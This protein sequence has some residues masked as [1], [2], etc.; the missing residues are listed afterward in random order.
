MQLYLLESQI[1]DA[2]PE[3]SHHCPVHIMIILVLFLKD[4]VEIPCEQ[5]WTRASLPNIPELLKKLNLSL[6]PLG[7]VDTCEPPVLT[8][9]RAELDK[10]QVIAKSGIVKRGKAIPPCHKNPTTHPN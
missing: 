1:I 5:P 4:E 10:D 6:I 3:P 7:P 9:S 8:C 2:S